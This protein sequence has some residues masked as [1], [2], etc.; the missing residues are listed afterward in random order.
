[1]LG[2]GSSTPSDPEC[3]VSGFRKWLDGWM[4]GG[5]REY[6]DKGNAR[7]NPC[8]TPFIRNI[9]ANSR[10]TELHWSSHVLLAVVL[11]FSDRFRPL[12]HSCRLRTAPSDKRQGGSSKQSFTYA[13]ESSVSPVVCL[14]RGSQTRHFFNLLVTCIR[15]KCLMFF[16]MSTTDSFLGLRWSNIFLMF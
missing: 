12:K 11:M 2:I 6:D 15:S 3:R 13:T 14:Y 7:K 16:I 9:K 4:G 10:W 1:M 5:S 8:Y